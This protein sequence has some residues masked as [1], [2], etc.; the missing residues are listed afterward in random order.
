[1]PK[2]VADAVSI[3]GRNKRRHAKEVRHVVVVAIVA[4]GQSSDGPEDVALLAGRGS[5]QLF[6]LGP[7]ESH[8][9]GGPTRRPSLHVVA[10]PSWPF[11][12]DWPSGAANSAL[13][14]SQSKDQDAN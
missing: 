11:Q 12:P 3:C 4:A 7:F 10:P 8:L 5:G 13:A 6:A 14:V 1:M 9:N 2:L